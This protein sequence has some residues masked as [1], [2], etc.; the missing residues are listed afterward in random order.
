MYTW[1]SQSQLNNFT[2]TVPNLN[3]VNLGGCGT[4]RT[5]GTSNQVMTRANTHRG[6]HQ[7]VMRC[8]QGMI[9]WS[10]R[11]TWWVAD[12]VTLLHWW[13]LC[14]WLSHIFWLFIQLWRPPSQHAFLL[15]HVPLCAWSGHSRWL[16]LHCFLCLWWRHCNDLLSWSPLSSR[17]LHS[18]RHG[19][20][21][22]WSRWVFYPR[23]LYVV[24][25]HIVHIVDCWTWYYIHGYPLLDQSKWVL[26]SCIL[27]KSA[28]SLLCN[29]LWPVVTMCVTNSNWSC[30][31]VVVVTE[32]YDICET[33]HSLVFPKKERKLDQTRL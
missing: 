22:S 7:G 30:L 14:P 3:L 11:S 10:N 27:Y 8:E 6:C 32:P 25:V 12:A 19:G 18:V 9:T 21:E 33:S 28:T 2:I 26:T 20:I 15:P 4:T 29:R 23:L 5:I 17:L 13:V 1:C 24:D 31:V 16:Q